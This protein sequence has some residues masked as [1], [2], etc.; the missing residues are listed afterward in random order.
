[1]S[2]SLPLEKKSATLISFLLLIFASL[3]LCFFHGLSFMVFSCSSPAPRYAIFLA[4]FI[5]WSANGHS[6]CLQFCWGLCI[7]GNSNVCAYVSYLTF[8]LGTLPLR[9]LFPWLK[10]CE[11]FTG[12]QWMSSFPLTSRLLWDLLISPVPICS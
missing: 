8:H 6:F 2:F 4:V 7:L 11:K 12:V 3:W 5:G 1:M 9:T 10:D